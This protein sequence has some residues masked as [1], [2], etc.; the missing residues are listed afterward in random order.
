MT[1]MHFM[2]PL[3]VDEQEGDLQGGAAISPAATLCLLRGR[4]FEAC[5]NRARAVV[6]YKHALSHDAYCYDAFRWGGSRFIVHSAHPSLLSYRFQRSLGS[7]FSYLSRIR[8]DTHFVFSHAS[9][10]PSSTGTCSPTRRR[11]SWW[12]ACTWRST[13]SG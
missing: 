3:Q 7:V 2:Y 11:W 9:A 4:A 13:T 8:P 10:V 5:Q 1:L 12:R 6:W